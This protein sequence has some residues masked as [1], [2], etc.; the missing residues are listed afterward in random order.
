MAKGD[1]LVKRDGFHVAVVDGKVSWV[2]SN[3]TWTTPCTKCHGRLSVH[4]EFCS[5]CADGFDNYGLDVCTHRVACS[6]K[7]GFTRDP[8]PTQYPDVQILNYLAKE[9][10]DL[11]RD[12]GQRLDAGTVEAK[13]AKDKAEEDSLKGASL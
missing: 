8:C 9:L 5:H 10:Q 2:E 11:F 3:P 1:L 4:P 7:N 6:C 13:I 12:Y